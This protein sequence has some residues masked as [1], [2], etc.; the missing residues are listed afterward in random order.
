MFR[1]RKQRTG[2]IVTV[3]LVSVLVVTVGLIVVL[4]A[5]AKKHSSSVADS[6]YNDYPTTSASPVP[7]TSTAFST[8]T[9]TTTT[10][11]AT[12]TS[13]SSRASTP[14]SSSSRPSGPQPV[15]QTKNN[16]LF[17]GENGTNTSTCNLPRWKSDPESAKAFFTATLP[18]LEAEWK[19]VL[20][21]AN[22]PYFSPKLAFPTGTTWNSPCGTTK[23]SEAAAFYCSAD[24][25]LYLPYE[26]LHTKEIGAHPGSY[27]AVM[28]HEFG[29]HVQA[30]SGV[31][32][33]SFDD[34][35]AAGADTAAGLEINR[36]FEL[37]A[38]CFGG[39]WFAGAWN[40]KGSIDDNIVNEMLKD[41]YTRGDD[42]NPNGPRDHGT[43]AHYGAWQQQGYTK[44]RTFQCNTYN[45]PSDAVS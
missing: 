12:A 21:R 6:G 8:T 20:A 11:S 27:L 4:S 26:G 34:E 36:R 14:T 22:L 29:H 32:D 44:N 42:N 41:G 30:V 13:S 38:E 1:P 24:N 2:L 31:M 16:P 37:Q 40:G 25:T 43:R 15:H 5:T 28:A 17:G 18:C 9:T 35:Y 10:S 45:V 3:S 23:G 33:A 39:M 7:T 19:P